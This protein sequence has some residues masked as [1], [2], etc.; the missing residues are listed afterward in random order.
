MFTKPEPR[1]LT[2]RVGLDSPG[3]HDVARNA[4]RPG[5]DAG[6]ELVGP[7]RYRNRCGRS[8]RGAKGP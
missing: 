5:E 7:R 2:M 8:E 3:H 6:W 1:H 4:A